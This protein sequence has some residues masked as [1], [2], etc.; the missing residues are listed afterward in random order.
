MHAMLEINVKCDHITVNKLNGKDDCSSGYVYNGFTQIILV[1][2][3]LIS[4]IKHRFV[5]APKE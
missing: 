3:V 1:L 5:V 4:P 2:G